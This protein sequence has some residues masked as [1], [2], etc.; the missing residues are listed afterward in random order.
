MKEYNPEPKCA[1]CGEQ[2]HIEKLRCRSCG[3]GIEGNFRL[4]TFANLD[5][6]EQDF[7]FNYILQNGS[8]K[9]LATEYNVSYPTVRTKLDKIIDKLK[10]SISQNKGRKSKKEKILELA[11]NDVIS[12]EAAEQIIR[13]IL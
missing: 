10:V 11:E 5:S 7:I 9:D 4:N 3:S 1:Y 12:I 2:M 8:L 6:D 13:S